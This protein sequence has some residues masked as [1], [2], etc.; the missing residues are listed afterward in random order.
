MPKCVLRFEGEKYKPPTEAMDLT[1]TTGHY[2]T[3]QPINRPTFTK[4]TSANLLKGKGEMEKNT[5]YNS[6]FTQFQLVPREN[7]K[8]KRPY[9]KP[10]VPLDSVTEAKSEYHA[11]TLVPREVMRSHDAPVKSDQPFV[12]STGYTDSFTAHTLEPRKAPERAIYA[13]PVAPLDSKTTVNES[14]NYSYQPPRQSFKPDSQQFKSDAAFDDIT[15]MH[16]DYHAHSVQPRFFKAP[17]QYEKPTAEM[18]LRTTTKNVYNEKS[19]ER[20]TF[21]KPSS[22]KNCLHSA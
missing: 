14:Y 12:G 8:P 20:L 9:E 13:G 18:D 10:S 21:K 2:F 11:H 15:T 4:P 5:N 7:M 19:L 16:T 17:R 22:S 6:D 3:E 1:T